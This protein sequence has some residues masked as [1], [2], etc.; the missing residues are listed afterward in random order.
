[1]T[2]A[3]TVLEAVARRLE[4]DPQ[5]ILPTLRIIA[6]QDALP[7]ATDTDTLE[8]AARVNVERLTA[9]LT[10]FRKHAVTTATVRNLLGGVTRQA[11]SHRVTHQQLLAAEIGGRLYFPD[12]Q[13][14]TDGPHQD[15]PQVIA[16]LTAGGRSALA[17]DALMRTPL[18]EE[19]GRSPAELLSK[20]A[21]DLA[22][23]Y[24][25]IAGGGF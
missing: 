5:H 2:G 7:A 3:N 24:I 19:D 1:M 22:M 4:D 13:F 16:A 23:H 10:A 12:W 25:T 15:L 9:R 14:G 20:G 8:L 6:D 17:A 18:P 21:T 11:V